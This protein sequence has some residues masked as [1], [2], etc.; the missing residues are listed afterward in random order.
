MTKS[1]KDLVLYLMNNGGADYCQTCIHLNKESCGRYVSPTD[2]SGECSE[3]YCIAGMGKHFEQSESKPKNL[4]KAIKTKLDELS[5]EI[6]T[7]PQSS[8][9]GQLIDALS[10]AQCCEEHLRRYF[11]LAQKASAG[12]GNV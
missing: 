1:E 7:L 9:N 11:M 5:E 2:Y 12:V 3:D 10:H 8:G 4:S 6:K